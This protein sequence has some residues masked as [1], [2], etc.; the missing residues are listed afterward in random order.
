MKLKISKNIQDFLIIHLVFA[1]I[2]VSALVIP[3]SGYMGIKLFIL[4]LIYNLIIP[5]FGYL[6]HH[7][8]WISIWLFVFILSLFQIWPDLFLSAE[9]DILVFPEDGFIKIGTVSLYMAGLWAIPLFLILFTGLHFHESYSKLK[10]YFIIALLSLIIFGS[11]E[12]TIWMLQSW[13]AQNVTMIGHIAIYVIIP[14]I[15][16]GITTFYGYKQIQNKNQLFKIPVAFLIML[17]YFGS[18]TFF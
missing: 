10:I 13:Y 7:R 5:L 1:A 4:V 6:R 2:C 17:L 16:L 12:Q 14:E 3:T 15:I 11:A 9:L 18:A 8:E